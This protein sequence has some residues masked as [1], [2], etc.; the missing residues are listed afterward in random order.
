MKRSL[1]D[2][3]TETVSRYFDRHDHL[4]QSEESKCFIN[5]LDIMLNIR[6]LQKYKFINVTNSLNSEKNKVQSG[7]HVENDPYCQ[8]LNAERRPMA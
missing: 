6:V 4:D 8:K 1:K 2:R 3:H 7:Y 5:K